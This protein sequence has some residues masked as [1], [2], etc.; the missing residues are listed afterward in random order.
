MAPFAEEADAALDAFD[1]PTLAQLR[2]AATEKR[3]AA[4]AE[5]HECQRRKGYHKAQTRTWHRLKGALL[6]LRH[7]D[8]TSLAPA[9]A[10]E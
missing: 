10:E 4:L 6:H 9:A 7:L 1:A 8:V 2:A 5:L 3:Q